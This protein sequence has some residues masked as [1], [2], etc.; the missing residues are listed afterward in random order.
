VLTRLKWVHVT[1]L[2]PVQEVRNVAASCAAAL[3]AGAEA[4]RTRTSA[5]GEELV[6]TL[7][8]FE[9]VQ[10][11]ADSVV[12]E[13]SGCQQ[14]CV[15]GVVRVGWGLLGGGG[16]LRCPNVESRTVCVLLCGG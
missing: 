8:S 11:E 10:E 14:A 12:V 13:V 1:R 6:A 4:L 2:L 9:E 15:P 16:V 3:A 7:G 5:L